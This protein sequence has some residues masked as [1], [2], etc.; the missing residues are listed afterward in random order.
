MHEED[1]LCSGTNLD[2][3]RCTRHRTPGLTVCWWHSPER[4]EARASALEEQ[5]A[6]IR[7]TLT[8]T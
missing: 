7:G 1:L 6:R 2:G 5:A 8:K 3:S 4:V